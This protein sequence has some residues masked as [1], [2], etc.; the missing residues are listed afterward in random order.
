MP[1]LR[2]NEPTLGLNNMQ[3]FDRTYTVQI[4][5]WE[6]SS[7]A[8]RISSTQSARSSNYQHESKRCNRGEVNSTN[9]NGRG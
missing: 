5:V 8:I 9:G 6:G 2:G 7:D 3:E 1:Q 4:G